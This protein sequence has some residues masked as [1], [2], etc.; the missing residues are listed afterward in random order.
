MIGL[1][2]NRLS[3]CRRGGMSVTQA[4][5]G[6]M[7]WLA[8]GRRPRWS[9][10]YSAQATA[11][12]KAQFPTQ[13]PTIRDY[14]FA[15]PALV[16]FIN[17]DQMLVMSLIEGLGIRATK[18]ATT[19]FN[20]VLET[21]YAIQSTGFKLKAYLIMNNTEWVTLWANG[22]DWNQQGSFMASYQS[23]N[24]TQWWCNASR[25]SSWS[26][27]SIN[28]VVDR[29]IWFEQNYNGIVQDG[30][31]TSLACNIIPPDT[32]K[33]WCCSGQLT[34]EWVFEDNG[35]VVRHFVPTR[36][37]GVNGL[38]EI[39]TAQ[40]IAPSSGTLTISETPAS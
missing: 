31:T 8:G 4:G 32:I 38:L 33:I 24:K 9:N 35:G 28:K 37:N 19:N 13:W 1:G 34:K 17:E 22:R 23:G 2:S 25:S 12:L 14:G 15:H 30:T 20:T 40:F 10:P 6:G 11:A 26:G 27:T 39:T 29:W 21:N 18:S 5:R 16:P 36:Q 3:V 7:E